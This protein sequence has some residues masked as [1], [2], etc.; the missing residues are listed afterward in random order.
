MCKNPS[1]VIADAKDDTPEVYA[2][3]KGDELEGLV[4]VFNGVL[5]IAYE[6]IVGDELSY[7]SK[8][9]TKN[10]TNMYELVRRLFHVEGGPSIEDQYIRRSY[11]VAAC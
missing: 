2:L 9:S 4:K 5:A 11:R 10:V 8:S 7:Y 1:R 6:I 3:Y